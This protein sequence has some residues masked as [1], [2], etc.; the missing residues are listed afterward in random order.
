[1]NLSD[2]GRPLMYAI[3][4]GGQ[5]ELVE[6]A[7]AKGGD[8]NAIDG[9]SGE[10]TLHAAVRRRD[11]GVVA[12]LIGAGADVN[13]AD[14][15]GNTPMLGA[16]HPHPPVCLEVVALLLRAG[17]RLDVSNAYG[18]SARDLGES[19]IDPAVREF[20]RKLTGGSLMDDNA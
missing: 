6:V 8:A 7:L 18:V 10:S 13:R 20:V 9:I 2:R 19:S 14:R 1:V 5:P 12:A 3:A 16:L 17:A 15:H 4:S 11:P